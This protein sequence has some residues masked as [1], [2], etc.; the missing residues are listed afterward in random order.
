MRTI[1]E[2]EEE[3]AEKCAY[4]SRGKVDRKIITFEIREN[5]S[6]VYFKLN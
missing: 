2:E 5:R 4:V 6:I 1:K 3:E